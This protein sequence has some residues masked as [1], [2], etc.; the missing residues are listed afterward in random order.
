MRTMAAHR[1]ATKS[2]LRDIFGTAAFTRG[3]A[4]ELIER[5]RNEREESTSDLRDQLGSYVANLRKAVGKEL[6]KLAATRVKMARL[7]ERARRAQLKDLRQRVEALLAS[8]DTLIA[9]FSE[10][11]R[12]AGRIWEQHVRNG[13]RQRRAAARA[14]ARDVAA[15][16]KQTARKTAKKRTR[17]RLSMAAPAQAKPA[18]SGSATQDSA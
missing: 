13:S 4:E 7:E 14:A 2:G 1:V 10:D 18:P 15:P 16:R 5:F 17:T 6:A 12:R 3:A 9:D 8:S 11:R